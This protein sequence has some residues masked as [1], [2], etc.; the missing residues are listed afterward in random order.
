MPTLTVIAGC[1]GSGKS[2]F[3]SSFLR[4]GLVSFDYDKVYLHIFFFARV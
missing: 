1:N 3:A 4:E 2:T